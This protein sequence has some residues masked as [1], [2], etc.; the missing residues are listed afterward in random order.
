MPRDP[1]HAVLHDPGE[2]YRRGAPAANRVRMKPRGSEETRSAKCSNEIG[3][4]AMPAPV[5]RCDRDL[6][7]ELAVG[8]LDHLRHLIKVGA[9]DDLR[10][11]LPAGEREAL[12]FPRQERM[13]VAGGERHEDV[14]DA[15]A[16]P[17]RDVGDA[18]RA[19]R[20]VRGGRVAEVYRA[21]TESRPP[22]NGLGP[23]CR[24]MVPKLDWGHRRALASA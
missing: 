8:L 4:S 18:Q 2:G 16:G 19:E 21:F 15:R 23:Y 20:S 9:V 17:G 14:E 24:C 6:R 7:G 11:D 5:A 12:A 13:V 22:F 10:V 1:G 3:S